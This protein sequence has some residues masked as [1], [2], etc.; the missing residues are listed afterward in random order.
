M[1]IKQRIPNPGF[2]YPHQTLVTP[3]PLESQL[4]C[5]LQSSQPKTGTWQ[6]DE[7]LIQGTASAAINSLLLCYTIQQLRN[8][9]I[10]GFELKM[11]LLIHSPVGCNTTCQWAGWPHDKWVLCSFSM[12]LSRSCSGHG[13]LEKLSRS[14]PS[15]NAT[16][17]AE[18]LQCFVFWTWPTQL[19]RSSSSLKD[20]C[21]TV[22]KQQRLSM[23]PVELQ[24]SSS[25]VWQRSREG[26]KYL[27]KYYFN[28][29]F[30]APHVHNWNPTCD[31]GHYL[32][33]S[34]PNISPVREPLFN[35]EQVKDS[36]L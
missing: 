7:L 17:P 30:I 20:L 16:R 36:A 10:I 21:S 23:C 11:P 34:Q 31:H 35:E 25:M 3:I 24:F 27:L 29:V 14:I 22:L 6:N 4:A 1:F 2:S 33:V 8:I 28:F 13:V 5:G 9:R 12:E 19:Q 15:T 26:I 32:S 18:F